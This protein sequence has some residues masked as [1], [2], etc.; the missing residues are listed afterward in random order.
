MCVRV[1]ANSSRVYSM[2]MHV[3]YVHTFTLQN[4]SLNELNFLPLF[5]LDLSGYVSEMIVEI[6]FGGAGLTDL[7]GSL[8]LV[9]VIIFLNGEGIT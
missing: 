6:S 1:T 4:S 7:Q 5:G 2:Y 9:R 8:I 3:Q